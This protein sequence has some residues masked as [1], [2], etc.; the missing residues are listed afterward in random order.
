MIEKLRSPRTPGRSA[1]IRKLNNGAQQDYFVDDLTLS[2]KGSFETVLELSVSGARA[3]EKAVK[4]DLHA[5]IAM[6]KAAVVASSRHPWR[7]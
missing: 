3:L 7:L 5:D 6:D 4:E 2:S 1:A